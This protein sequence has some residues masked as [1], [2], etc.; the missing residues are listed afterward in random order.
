MAIALGPVPER[1]NSLIPGINVPYL[2]IYPWDKAHLS[3]ELSYY[4]FQKPAPGLVNQGSKV[5]IPSGASLSSA[6]IIS[7]HV[8]IGFEIGAIS[9]TL[10]Q[11]LE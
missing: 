8:M 1:C 6:F 11:V 4:T 7:S 9:E 3:L 10:T 2:V 5:Q